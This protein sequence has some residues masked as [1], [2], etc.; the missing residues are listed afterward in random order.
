MAVPYFALSSSL[1]PLRCAAIS[2]RSSF[3]KSS[4][5]SFS[6]STRAYASAKS[7]SAYEMLRSGGLSVFAKSDVKLAWN[8]S[9]CAYGVSFFL[10]HW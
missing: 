2:L 8:T 4:R 6:R 9:S 7:M 5:A 3:D 10:A 1:I